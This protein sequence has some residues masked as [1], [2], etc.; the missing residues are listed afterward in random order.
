MWVYVTECYVTF[1]FYTNNFHALVPGCIPR[2]T[3]QRP[4]ILLC[5]LFP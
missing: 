2:Y 4:T 1:D 3:V 5:V